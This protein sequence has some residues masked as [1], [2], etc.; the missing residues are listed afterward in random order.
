MT[1][2]LGIHAHPVKKL[3]KRPKVDRATVATEDFFLLDQLPPHPVV[4][5]APLLSYPMDRNDIAG[6]CVVAGT[7][8]ALQVIHTALQVPRAL[9]TDAQLLAYYQ[10]QNPDFR[11]WADSGTNADQG[12]VI[13][14]FLED[15]VRVGEIVAFGAVDP[16]NE[17]LMKAA[18][19]VG[20]AIITGEDLRVAQ[21]SQQTWDYVA[22]SPDWGGHCTTTVGY[23]ADPDRQSC[24]SWGELVPMTEPFIEHQMSEA[25]LILTRAHINNPE[26]RNAFNLPA[27]AAAI[28]E[29]TNGKVIVPTPPVPTPIPPPPTPTPPPPLPATDPMVDFPAAPVRGWLRTKGHSKIEKTAMQ[30]MTQWMDEHDL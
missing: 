17:E 14:L 11:S 2:A 4:N 18:T 7:N 8:H 5:P 6:V 21:Q 28:A 23:A 26:F 12:M 22:R 27:F 3:G 30:A 25:W 20:L 16:H 13:Q 19:Y 15:L 24:V 29:L 10:T 1:E 9:W